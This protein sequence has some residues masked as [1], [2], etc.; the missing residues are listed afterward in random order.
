MILRFDS[1]YIILLI[2][3]HTC[4]IY[5]IYMNIHAYISC[6]AH[7]LSTIGIAWKIQVMGSLQGAKLFT[8]G[9]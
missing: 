7:N 5:L 8:M 3:Y 1:L 9:S 2:F 6:I 4:I